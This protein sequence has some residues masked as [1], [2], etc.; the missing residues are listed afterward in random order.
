MGR[1][2]TQ[3]AV[4]DFLQNRPLRRFAQRTLLGKTSKNL[5]ALR[6][7]QIA[8]VATPRKERYKNNPLISAIDSI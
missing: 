7:V 5:G 8:V 4:R 3:L 6:E 2:T 1:D